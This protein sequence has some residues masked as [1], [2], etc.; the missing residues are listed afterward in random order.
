MSA[1]TNLTPVANR[2]LICGRSTV[3]RSGPGTPSFHTSEKSVTYHDDLKLYSPDLKKIGT[4]GSI[5]ISH[6]ELIDDMNPFREAVTKAWKSRGEPQTSNVYDGEMN[7]LTRCAD[8][9]YKGVR[10][11]SYLFLKN[12]RNITVLPEVLSKRLIIDD[13][14]RTCKGVTVI[15]ASG[16][17]LNFYASRE[18]ILSQ[19]VFKSPKPLMLSGIGP[20]RELAQHGIDVIVDSRHVGQHLSD[21]PG[22][23]FVL[24][25]RDGF[26]MDD[27]LLRKTP[28]NEAVVSAYKKDH[29]GPVGSGLLELVGFSRIDKYIEKD[30]AYKK[31][32][33]ANGG[34]DP[35]SP[36]GQPHFELDFVYMFGSAF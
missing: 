1:S 28:K 33:A 13:V 21:H 12:K 8:T 30:P 3:G 32:K 6:A 35:F 24:R 7:G 4:D 18:V 26:S 20:A 9:I 22:V 34:K 17:E 10:S 36:L 29:S 2:P 31:A 14:D 27:I 23:P 15:A 16:K 25:V 5:H 11:G 19:G